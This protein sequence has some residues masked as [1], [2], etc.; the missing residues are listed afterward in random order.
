MKFFCIGAFA[1]GIRVHV[2]ADSRP[3]RTTCCSS[4]PARNRSFR[5]C[6]HSQ[7]SVS[8]SGASP[9]SPPRLYPPTCVAFALLDLAFIWAAALHERLRVPFA[10]SRSCRRLA[11]PHVCFAVFRPCSDL[12][13]PT[14]TPCFQQQRAHKRVRFRHRT[15]A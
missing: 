10:R 6:F 9:E 1:K 11:T 13:R 3:T 15:R 7:R 14:P 8:S 4:N 5:P 2:S 12:P